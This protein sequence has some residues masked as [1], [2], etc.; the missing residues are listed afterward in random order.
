MA[1]GKNLKKQ[2][3]ISGEKKKKATKKVVKKKLITSEKKKRKPSREEEV[4]NYITE[5]E[6]ERKKKLRETHVKEIAAFSGRQV[7]FVII[8][9]GSEEY[10]LDISAI[11]EVVVV[12]KLSEA[13]STETPAHIK[14]IASVREKT[15]LAMDLA[16]KF[17]K[18]LRTEAKYLLTLNNT[19]NSVGFLLKSLPVT[20][21]V[22]G[23]DVSS[24]LTML[25]TAT[26]NLS[27][28][29]GIIQLDERLIFYLDLNELIASDKAI[30]VPDE[31]LN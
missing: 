26:K 1:L 10:A 19:G 21:K 17:N 30:V 24:D 8:T 3:L 18:S 28:I 13:P 16:T 27:Y 7:Q 15:F 25:D 29:K 12:P 5:K 31:L 6:Q 4:V 2:Q 9:I 22:S 11:R 20:L 23:D 14:G